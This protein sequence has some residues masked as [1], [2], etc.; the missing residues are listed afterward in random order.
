MQEFNLDRFTSRLRELMYNNF[1][2]ENDVINLKK[3]KNRPKHIRD[4]AF[5]DNP[6]YVNI[7][8]RTFDIGGYMAESQYPYY[9]ILQD[10]PVIRKRDRATSKTKGSQAKIEKLGLRDYNKISFNGKTYSR[11]YAKNVRGKRESVVDKSTQ[12]QNG[13]KIN[14]SANNY[15]NIHYQYIDRT[16]DLI[17]P[18]LAQEFGGKLLRKQNTGLEEDYELS[19]N[20]EFDERFAIEDMLSSY[21]D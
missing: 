1:P 16:L 18:L 7:N 4:I 12:W 8:S 14:K 15:K 10:S 6:I 19:Q 11:E 3:H 17:M 9:H 13:V 20:I 5:M 21:L 2:Y